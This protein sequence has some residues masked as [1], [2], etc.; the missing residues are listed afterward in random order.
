MIPDRF[1][2]GLR[3]YYI[4]RVRIPSSGAQSRQISSMAKAYHQLL[5]TR[6]QLMCGGRQ[7]DAV[8][9]PCRWI[10]DSERQ[11]RRYLAAC[12]CAA[13]IVLHDRRAFVATRDIAVAFSVLLC[14][15]RVVFEAHDVPR[16]FVAGIMTG[17]S[18]RSGRFH[19][20]PN[21]RALARHYAQRFRFP[22]GRALPLHNG[23]FIED[24][25]QLLGM[26]KAELKAH[27]QL[28]KDRVLVVH[29]GSLYK[30]G[31][32][33]FGH[34]ACYDRAKIL[35]VHLG[36]S[37]DECER[38]SQTYQRQ[39]ISNIIFIPNRSP[40]DVRRY[41]RAADLL[42]YVSTRKSPIWRFTS[43][44]KI[45]EY[46]ASGTPIIGTTIGS[47][48]EV[49][50]ETNAYCY[51]PDDP[52][53]ITAALERYFSS[54]Q[55]AEAIAANARHEAVSR[56]SWKERALQVIGFIET[57]YRGGS[58]CMR[59]KSRFPI[60]AGLSGALRRSC[61][62][63]AVTRTVRAH[64]ARNKAARGSTHIPKVIYQ[65]IADKRNIHPVLEQNIRK[66]QEMN[67]G[68]EHVLFDDW[69]QLAF[70]R[71]H[72]SP[73]E[74]AAYLSIDE[75]YGAAR[76]DLF[77]YVLMY[78]KGGVYLDIKSSASLP[79]D[80]MLLR[81]DE[82]ILA[83][84]KT[85]EHRQ[86]LKNANGEYQQ[87][88]LIC[89]PGHP[90]LREVIDRV[91]ENIRNYSPEFDGVGKGGVLTLTG[92]IAYTRAI[93]PLTPFH[94]HSEYLRN[95][96]IGLVYSVASK[97]LDFISHAPL[98]GTAHYSRLSVPIVSPHTMDI[99]LEARS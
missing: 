19:L 46:M 72:A 5:G 33:L 30:G 10:S 52:P 66:L 92:P 86:E 43:P 2:P 65:T 45:F 57:G 58:V 95:E 87:W 35:F 53:S 77:R 99:Q 89:R 54:P 39:G 23:C 67:P 47:V 60:F 22:G 7:S 83:H 76:A 42:F 28:P 98:L 68:W 1:S 17:T 97:R 90:F 78:H 48:G 73:Q 21:C 59:K 44:L 18:L 34:V 85:K 71:T 4:T 38:W 61:D 74:L 41:Q 16:G 49:L 27:L 37:E 36:G 81:D 32:E 31:A 84:W 82:Y 80:V 63:I 29:T 13:G 79:F 64:V 6:F 69:D 9:L 3:L 15:G 55:K 51:D 93:E 8:D 96:W 26:E 20:V 91:C 62:R 24:Y 25:G 75:R 11:W 70:M 14:G 56:Y 12:M 88:H 94:K 40:D 50:N